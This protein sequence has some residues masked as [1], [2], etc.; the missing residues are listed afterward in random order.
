[1]DTL[2]PEKQAQLTALIDELDTFPLYVRIVRCEEAM[3]LDPTVEADRDRM[4]A[5]LAGAWAFDRLLLYLNRLRSLNDERMQFGDA[6]RE[7]KRH[8]YPSTAE[9][10]D[11]AA[12][13]RVLAPHFAGEL[14]VVV[15]F[16]CVSVQH[17]RS[18]LKVVAE[19]VGYEICQDDLDYLDE[20]RFLRNHFE[21]WYSRLPGKVGEAG[22]MT[23]TVTA[24]GYH[25]WGGLRS[26]AKDRVIVIEPKKSGPVTHVVDVTNNGVAR[27]EKIVQE[28]GAQVRKLTLERVRA[29]FIAHPE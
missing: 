4:D 26:D 11:A 7:L 19:A 16:F 22:L 13:A 18:L 6:I 10:V 23:K 2:T 20:F 3:G 24:D 14:E 17:I 28:T 25:V 1:M 12:R 21:H 8:P 5:A 9:E 27:I 29:H 15:N